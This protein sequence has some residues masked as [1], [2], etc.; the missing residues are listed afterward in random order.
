[1]AEE[2][3]VT[4]LQAARI[5]AGWTQARALLALREASTA[6]GISIASPGSLKTMLS[7]W[8]NGARVDP[9]YQRL[10]CK[11]YGH[12]A[13][14]LGFDTEMEAR[15]IRVPRVAAT[16]NADMVG[17][18]KNIFAAHIHADS[19]FGP[20][21]LIDV[22]QAQAALL[23]Q[24]LLNARGE[25]RS[26]LLVL[27]C[28]YNEF[29]GWLYQDSGEPD[30]AMAFSDRAMD[31]ALEI[32]D[33]RE[34]AY[35][36]MRKANIAIDQGKPGRALGLA[37]AALRDPSKV[38]PRIR[39][40][41]LGQ[42]ARAHAHLAEA[43]DCRRAVDDAYREVCRPDNDSADL[44]PYCN[45]S[46]IAMEAAASWNRIGR[47]DAAVAAYEPSLNCWPEGQQR[48]HGVF[49]ARL[50]TAY[51]G[52]QDIKRACETG[53]QAI[54]VVQSAT[55]S[56]ALLELAQVRTRLA[57]WRHDGEVSDLRRQ[58]RDL[59]EPMA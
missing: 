22:V 7:R 24:V 13:Q 34:T 12:T 18:F 33:P 44:A 43:D 37:D 52:R 27:A 15:K 29:A 47:F 6:D 17:Y 5:D 48:D 39:A 38:P 3:G 41:I 42:R 1:M 4:P 19:L 16:V 51:A 30:N 2:R 55:S 21:H 14:E 59:I 23:D 10:L 28:R 20:H 8:E 36:L 32:N 11:I 46:Y 26:E 58:I 45:L 57:P 25:V 35:V 9:V 50:T 53:H 56:R 54:G 40:L 31:Y 49:L